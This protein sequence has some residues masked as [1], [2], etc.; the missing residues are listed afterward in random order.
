[1]SFKVIDVGKTESLLAETNA[2][3]IHLMLHCESC[4]WETEDYLH[5]DKA[6]YDHVQKTGHK[7]SGEYGLS[8]DFIPVAERQTGSQR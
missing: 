1:M 4:P 6:A 8:V 5:G 7:V 3:R 2:I